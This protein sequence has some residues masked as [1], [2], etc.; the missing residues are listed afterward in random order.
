MKRLAVFLLLYSSNVV[1]DIDEYQ[2]EELVGWTIV[3]SKSI[4]GYRDPGEKKSDDWEGC[5]FDRTVYFSDGTTVTC[6]SYGYQYAYMPKAILFGHEI[7]HE[8]KKYT[9]Y[10]MLVQGQLYDVR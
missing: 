1:A 8:G 3:A 9:M 10:K 7:T 6:Y 5:D 4:A 2:L